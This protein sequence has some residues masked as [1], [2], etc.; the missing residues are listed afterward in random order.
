MRKIYMTIS[1]LTVLA[2]SQL[3]A[4]SLEQARTQ[5]VVCEGNNG[6]LVAQGSAS[7]DVQQLISSVNAQRQQEYQ[8]IQQ[9]NGSN[10]S[11]VDVMSIAAQQIA[12]SVPSGTFVMDASG[13]CSQK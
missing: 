9:S 3:S 10:M 11:D 13:N 2:S 4:I 6:L 5:G 12:A 8:N 7:A 1:A